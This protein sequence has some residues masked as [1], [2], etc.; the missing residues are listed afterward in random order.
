MA[1]LLEIHCYGR[2]PSITIIAVCKQHHTR[3]IDWNQFRIVGWSHY[4]EHFK[5]KKLKKSFS[6]IL[7]TYLRTHFI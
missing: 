6:N 4:F 7:Q 1:A 2:N 3:S 5:L